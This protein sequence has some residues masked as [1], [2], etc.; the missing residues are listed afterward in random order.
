MAK[1]APRKPQL[2]SKQQREAIE[3]ELSHPYGH[4]NLR[5]DG[6][7]IAL[8]VERYKALRY[9]VVVYVD[10]YL[11]GEYFKSDSAVG[12]KFWRPETK[13][14]LGRKAIA[15]HQKA[16]GKR[17][18]RQLQ[19]RVTSTVHMPDF[20]SARGFLAHA[21]RTCDGIEVVAVGCQPRPSD[22]AQPQEAVANG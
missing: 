12:A 14:A 17:A 19:A 21:Q 15:E 20:R 18:A 8:R 6:H 22:T 3:K 1:P 13:S 9:V 5:I 4:V 16:W 10:G 11:K 7:A 2:L